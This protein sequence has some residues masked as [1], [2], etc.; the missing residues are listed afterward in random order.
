VRGEADH[1]RVHGLDLRDPRVEIPRLRV[2]PMDRHAG[3]LRIGEQR[4]FDTTDSMAER[5][6]PTVR[7]G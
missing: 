2:D 1:V 7:H 3:E 6:S 4:S 5:R